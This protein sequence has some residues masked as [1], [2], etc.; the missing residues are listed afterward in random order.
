[1][2]FK[3]KFLTHASLLTQCSRPCQP[4]TLSVAGMNTGVGAPAVLRGWEGINGWS[5][6]VRLCGCGM[7]TYELT[8]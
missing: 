4:W 6:V 2:I 5:G 1:M 3:S 7:S 8:G